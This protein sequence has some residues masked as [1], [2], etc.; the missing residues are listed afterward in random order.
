MR[1]ALAE[2]LPIESFQFRWPEG[3]EQF[4]HGWEGLV[5]NAGRQVGFRHGVG[6]RIVY[7]RQRVHTV[8]FLDGKPL[9]EGV[10]SDDFEESGAV[11]SLIKPGPGH[12]LARELSEVPLEYRDFEIVSH[13]DEIQ[14]PYSKRCL[15]LKIGI[16]DCERWATHAIRTA[17]ARNTGSRSPAGQRPRGSAISAAADE[18]LSG[19]PSQLV[20]SPSQGAPSVEAWTDSYIPYEPRDEGAER[21]RADLRARLGALEARPDQV[22]HCLFTGSKAVRTDIENVLLYNIDDTGACFQPAAFRGLVFEHSTRKPRPD[23]SGLDYACHYAYRL[24]PRDAP[25]AAWHTGATVARWDP[26]DLGTFRGDKKL[27]AI[28]WALSGS[29]VELGEE[30]AAQK[31]FGVRLSL[32]PPQGVHP[33]TASLVKPLMDGVV[34][35]FQ[36]HRDRSTVDEVAERLAETLDAPAAEIAARLTSE[37]RAVL[38]AVPRLLHPRGNGVQWAPADHLLVA[39]SLLIMP[40]EGQSWRLDGLVHE[41]A[42]F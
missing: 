29:T 39:G 17:A 9:V 28:W 21:L 4:E 40:P 38:G 11:L 23:P 3:P 6:S 32:Y 20:H 18:R 35:A 33:Q 19:S 24:V 12:A 15:A 30:R 2:L 22:L 8:T 31:P 36:A 26:V 10:E 34:C 13:C 7:D 14:A 37:R 1:L 42:P 16:D 5:R 41:V 27:A 25:L